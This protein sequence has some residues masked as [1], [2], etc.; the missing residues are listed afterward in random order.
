MAS[1]GHYLIAAALV[2]EFLHY[3]Y[4]SLQVFL[5]CCVVGVSVGDGFCILTVVDFNNGLSHLK[6]Q[7]QTSLMR[8]KIHSLVSVRMGW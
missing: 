8:V 7:K 6:K 3:F 4:P 5:S 2:L 1:R